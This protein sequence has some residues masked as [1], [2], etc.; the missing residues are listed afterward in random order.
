MGSL[1]LPRVPSHGIPWAPKGPLP[2]D[3]LGSR[4]FPSHGIPWAPKGPLP[5]D[6]FV[7]NT[8]KRFRYLS[9]ITGL[10]LPSSGAAS[11]STVAQR[12]S[13]LDL[14]ARATRSSTSAARIRSDRSR[15][16]SD[17][18][19]VV[20]RSG[21]SRGQEQ[22]S[23]LLNWSKVRKGCLKVTVMSRMVN[24]T[25]CEKGAQK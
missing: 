8:N 2:L 7:K 24:T 10:R 6:P 15:S 5:W 21:A 11:I 3:L 1:G 23:K 20:G 9:P 25:G 22:N 17:R 14:G 13:A 19:R 18:S 12:L 16:R 4:G